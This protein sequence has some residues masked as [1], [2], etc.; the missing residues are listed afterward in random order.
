MTILKGTCAAGQ[1]HYAM[2]NKIFAE[3]CLQQQVF[4]NLPGKHS[5]MFLQ[6]KDHFQGTF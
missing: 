6:T 5:L 1:P 3:N 4:L 2:E